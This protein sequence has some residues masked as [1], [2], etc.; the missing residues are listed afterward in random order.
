M[1]ESS[2]NRKMILQKRSYFKQKVTLTQDRTTLRYP[3]VFLSWYKAHCADPPLAYTVQQETKNKIK[4]FELK[5]IV[6]IACY[7]RPQ[8]MPMNSVVFIM[9]CKED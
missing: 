3:L 8:W 9:L 5:A 6:L 7:R 1:Y 4:T 2:N